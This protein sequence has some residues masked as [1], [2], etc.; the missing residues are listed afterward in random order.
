MPFK[1]SVVCQLLSDLEAIVT[2]NPPSL[3]R[4]RDCEVRQKIQ[5]WFKCNRRSID[6]DEID[7]VALLSTLLPEK[8]TDRVYGLQEARLCKILAR[9]LRLNKGE[10]KILQSWN[11]PGS[12]DLGA[13]VQRLLKAFDCEQ[14]PGAFITVE[15]V[16]LVMHHLASQCRFSAPGIRSFDAPPSS[17]DERLAQIFRRLNSTDAKWFTR[18]ILKDF[19]AAR[20]DNALVISEYH[21]LLP[22]LLRFQDSLVSAGALLATVLSQY[23][24]KP[25][26]DVQRA[27]RLD[28]GRLLAP[29]TGTKVGRQTYLKARSMQHCVNMCGGQIWSAER[30]Y[31]GEYCE[32][33]V[34]VSRGEQCI[35]IFSKSGKD[36][37][38]DRRGIHKAL[39]ECLR[40]GEAGC[41]IKQKCIVTGELVVWSDHQNKIL[42]FYHLRKH[43]SRSGVFLGRDVDSQI[44]PGEHLMMIFYDILLLDNEML[45]RKPYARRRDRMK[46]VV[47][48]REGYAMPA[49]RAVIDF[50]D[51][52]KA[53]ERLCLYFAAALAYRCEGLVLKPV[54]A[55]YFRFSGDE[56]RDEKGFVIKLKKD[57]L[58]EMG[59]LRDV[60][61][62]A[63]VGA[64][65]DP[66]L[67]PKSSIRN[68]QYTT[69]HLGCCVNKA[70]AEQYG[71][72]PRFEIVAAISLDQCIPQRELQ[73]LNNYTIF[74]SREV[75][76]KGDKLEDPQSF[77][78]VFTK[79]PESKVQ[80]VLNEPCVV[81]VLGSGFERPSNKKYW[82]L[83]H[84]RILKLHAD[85]T[86]RE[87]CTFSDLQVLAEEAKAAPAEGESQEMSQMVKKFQFK[88]HH[89]MERERSQLTSTPDRASTVGTTISPQSVRSGL[90]RRTVGISTP[91]KAMR[92]SPARAR[93]SPVL[94]RIDTSERL[95]DEAGLMAKEPQVEES[96]P[97]PPISSGNELL[98]RPGLTKRK[99]TTPGPSREK[100]PR[101]SEEKQQPTA[102]APRSGNAQNKPRAQSASPG[103]RSAATTLLTRSN[104]SPTRTSQ[105]AHADNFLCCPNANCPFSKATVF[106]TPCVRNFPWVTESLLPWHN[107]SQ[108]RTLQQWTREPTPEDAAIPES[109]A[110]PSHQKIILVEP[111]RLEATMSCIDEVKRQGIRGLVLVFDWRVLEDWQGVEI[112]ESQREVLDAGRR[113]V[114]ERRFFGFTCW[115]AGRGEVVFMREG[116]AR[117]PRA[118]LDE[119]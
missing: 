61:D 118:W 9:C 79:G 68:I 90:R 42:D 1:F 12:G 83:R 73:A 23:P 115:D 56:K 22:S 7:G 69:F 25:T 13:C 60:A 32:V 114:L 64:S 33:H 111:N 20:L 94:V 104:T 19:S 4:D 109:Y 82:M 117:M 11:S 6:L 37:T 58:Q 30:K 46:E 43:V 67:A 88:F 39:R 106:L 34:D 29:A 38:E 74:H 89:R 62:F 78:L 17:S 87:A 110:F 103:K 95:P 105:P 93:P 54:D 57:H 112:L 113:G 15:E 50:R 40:L 21:F 48:Y 66:K 10:T 71:A 36:S 75:K 97:T 26:A 102:L 45:L 99:S 14:K 35:Q 119:L 8:R 24:S 59:E 65:Y 55:A 101:P 84:P 72:L 18:L 2:R 49:E 51:L 63:V 53:Q 116:M 107:A 41:L 85:R 92:R 108:I 27:G 76:Q 96:L 98:A 5:Y 77:D 44:K 80:F 28:A 31:D 70:D 100:R 16:D 52:K 91:S 3:P 47:R 81:E 86:W